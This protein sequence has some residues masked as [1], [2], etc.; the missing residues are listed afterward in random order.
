MRKRIS[1]LFCLLASAP[2]AAQTFGTAPAPLAATPFTR[3]RPLVQ[4]YANISPPPASRANQNYAPK[5][6]P[7]PP[8]PAVAVTHFERECI[9]R[10]MMFEGRSHSY[11]SMLAVGTI[12]ANRANSGHWSPTWCGVTAQYKQFT[13][14]PL[15]RAIVTPF[16]LRA[17]QTAYAI[18]AEI[19]A[20]V[21]HPALNGV[22]HFRTDGARP[23]KNTIDVG[24][25][26]GNT[27]YV[28]AAN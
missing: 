16:D 27:F 1:I 15:D 3:P 20:G 10:A 23:E 19:E 2:C 24:S 8:P 22:F 5:A 6:L 28:Y 7:A 4:A 13:S 12:I 26:G 21:R 18:A 14:N 25:I 17:Y 9:A 11:E